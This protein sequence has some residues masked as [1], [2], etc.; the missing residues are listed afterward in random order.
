MILQRVPNALRGNLTRLP[1]PPAR[2]CDTFAHALSAWRRTGHVTSKAHRHRHGGAHRPRY[3]EG[4]PA[5]TQ[6]RSRAAL[7]R[8][9]TG[10]DTAALTGRAT[11]KAHRHRHGGAHRPRYIEGSPASTRRRSQAALHRRLTGIDTTA[12]I[13][14]HPTTGLAFYV[15]SGENA[16]SH[17]G[18]NCD[19]EHV[20]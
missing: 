14:T 7:H 20:K 16:V 6:R 3:I 9:F 8:R 17:C 18:E 1:N 4:S 10:I 13:V 19:I 15:L 12:L 5:S 11:S 2:L